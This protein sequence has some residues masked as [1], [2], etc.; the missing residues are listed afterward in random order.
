MLV[1]RTFSYSDTQRYRV[2]PNYLQLPVNQ[3]KG[4]TVATN[5]RD[6]QMAFGVDLAPGQNPHINYEPSTLGGL[7]EAPKPA[8]AEQ[9][10]V[11]SGRLTRARIERTNDYKQTG[12]HYQLI[13]Q[14]EKDETVANFIDAF[15][16]CDR[17]IQ[18][19][20]V[21]HFL[22]ADDEL[23]ARIGEGIGI[24][25]DDVR[26]LEPLPTQTLNDE[27]KARLANLGKNGPRDVT[28]LVMT[29]C[30]PNERVVVGG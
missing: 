27:E 30:V 2:G 7:G 28:G 4:A 1:G 21:W 11:V 9:G 6:G 3:A 22:L 16:Q 17:H 24:T 5:Q 20:M 8:H 15:S 12:E 23:G 18:E 29:H 10:P 26:H 13:E 14:W 25:A 19:R